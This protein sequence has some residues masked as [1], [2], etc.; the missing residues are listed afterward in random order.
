MSTPAEWP[1]VIDRDEFFRSLLE[2]RQA[3]MRRRWLVE[4]IS[5]AVMRRTFDGTLRLLV[6]DQ[7]SA[8]LPSDKGATT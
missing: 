1:P 7:R 6:T 4:E 2:R 8:A 3:D 5:E